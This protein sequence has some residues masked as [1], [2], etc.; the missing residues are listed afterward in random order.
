MS[1]HVKAKFGC[2]FGFCDKT[3]ESSQTGMLSQIVIAS[4]VLPDFKIGSQYFG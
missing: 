3:P 1:E 2:G 4:L